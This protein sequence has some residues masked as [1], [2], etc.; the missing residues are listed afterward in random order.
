LSGLSAFASTSM[1]R[2]SPLRRIPWHPVFRKDAE[3]LAPT[4]AATIRL[5]IYPTSVLLRKG[6]PI[7]VAL[8]GI[9]IKDLNLSPSDYFIFREQVSL[10]L[11]AQK[12]WSVDYDG[13]RGSRATRVVWSGLTLLFRGW[14]FRLQGAMHVRMRTLQVLIK[15]FLLFI[16]QDFAHFAVGVHPK[17]PDFIQQLIAPN[18]F[19]LHDFLRGVVQFLKD[20]FDFGLLIGGEIKFFG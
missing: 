10:S 1:K 18:G 3:P 12:V 6:H 14:S 9:D 2:T 19:V 13:W 17:R 7:H 5:S 15:F 4:A 20:G 16:A 8:A 11:E